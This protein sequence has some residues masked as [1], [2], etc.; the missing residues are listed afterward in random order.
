MLTSTGHVTIPIV[1]TDV[2][3]TLVASNSDVNNGGGALAAG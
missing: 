1:K 2:N 3:R